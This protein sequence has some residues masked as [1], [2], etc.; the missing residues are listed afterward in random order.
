MLKKSSVSI[1][2]NRIRTLVTSD[3]MQC[4]PVTYDTIFRE[5]YET[6]SKYMEFTEE[7]FD[8]EINRNRIIITFAG[9]KT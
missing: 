2:K 9:E 4:A 8:V 3:R 7:D 6:L 1:A 5:L